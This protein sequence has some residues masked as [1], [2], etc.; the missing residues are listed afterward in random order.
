MDREFAASHS[1]H[2]V[3]TPIASSS[4]SFGDLLRQLRRRAGLTQGELAAR[5]GYSVAQISRLEQNERLPTVATVAETFAPALD[6]HDEPHLAHRLVELAALARGERPPSAVRVTRT[7]HTTIAEEPL[8]PAGLFPTP[9]LPLVGRAQELEAVAQRLM[10]APGRLVTLIGPPGVGKTQLSQAVAERVAT[11]FRDGVWFV[12]LAAVDDPELVAPAIASVLDLGGSGTVAPAARLIAQLRRKETL[13]VLDN[14]EQVTACAPLLVSLLQACPGLRILVTSTEPLRLRSEQRHKVP[15]LAPA[16]SAE[17]FIQRAQAVDPDFA[18]TAENAGAITELCLRLDCLPLA[19]ELLAARIDLLTPTAMLA[20]LS[21]RRLDL[22][23]HGPVDLEAHHGTLRAAIQ[24]GYDLLTATEQSL[25]R[26]LGVYVGGCDLTSIAAL[27]FDGATARALLNK[28]MLHRATGDRASA[29]FHL[30][31]TLRDFA[32]EALNAACEADAA[33]RQH[34]A[35]FLDLATQ[36]STQWHSPQHQLWL[37]RLEV[38]HDNLRAAMRWLLDHDAAAA[39]QMAAALREF[40]YI[41]GHF[42]EARRLLDAALRASTAPTAARGQALLAAARLAHAQDENATGLRLVEEALPLLRGAGDQPGYA[43]ALRTGGW[44]AHSAGQSP[45]AL[46]MFS[47]AL[48]LS[49]TLGAAA[50][51]ADLHISIAQLYALDGDEAHFAAARRD[52]AAGLRIARQLDRQASV[53]YALHGEASLELMAGDYARA[54]RLAGEAL[55]LFRALDFRRNVPLAQLLI[56]EAALLAG[57]L[58]AARGHAQAAQTHY[59]ELAIPWGMAAALQLLGQVA[60]FSGEPAQARQWLATS[61]ALSWRLRDEKLIAATLAALGGVALAEGEHVRAAL[62]LA[63]A[64][65]MFD[66]LP[67]FLAPGYRCDYANLRVATCAALGDA[68]FAA[69]WAVGQAL[70]V[71]QAVALAAG[72]LPAPAPQV[73]A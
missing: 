20:Q 19:I 43:E 9:L 24:R 25:L 22:L 41:R 26:R 64:Q 12:P 68:Q 53:A 36:A 27:G 44:I 59:E 67:R 45:R 18:A 21:D 32:L 8:T 63:A 28:S 2:R 14:V 7:V 30:L 71:E 35:Y 38:E 46:A 34:A 60:R 10:R 50:L 39:Q 23:T 73:W 15:P 49:Q 56:G 52:F 69:T 1:E 65:Q 55:A 16:A 11:L 40:W 4:L 51:T 5:V 33:R 37:D 61:L 47:E 31:E 54:G 42:A 66:R 29:R 72:E 3:T 57:D 70:T 58:P 17:L 62:L 13:L 48:T 6:L